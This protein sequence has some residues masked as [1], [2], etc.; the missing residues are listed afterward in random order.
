MA[1][2]IHNYNCCQSFLIM[3]SLCETSGHVQGIVFFT[4]QVVYNKRSSVLQPKS[5]HI[6]PI[7]PELQKERFK[8][9][10]P[11]NNFPSN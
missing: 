6:T 3:S 9:A 5:L 4:G 11:L 2:F 1:H 7:W 8:T 10:V